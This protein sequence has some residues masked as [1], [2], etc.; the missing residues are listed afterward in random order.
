MRTRRRHRFRPTLEL[1]ENRLTPSGNVT[2]A[3]SGGNLTITGDAQANGIALSQ[4]AAGAI[5]ITPDATTRVNGKAAGTPVTFMNV[6]GNVAI[7]L[8]AGNDSLTFDLSHGNLAVV[9]NLTATFGNGSPTVATTTAGT[10]NELM[11]GG[12]LTEKFGNGAVNTTLDQFQVGGNLTI[13]HGNGSAFVTFGVDPANLGKQFNNVGGNLAVLNVTPSGAPAGGFDIDDLDE[14]NVAGNVD[15]NMGFG[16]GTGFAG[17]TS[18][19]SES[20]KQVSVGGDLTITNLTGSMSHGD[21]FNDG[22]EVVNTAVGGEVTMNLGA[23]PNNTAAFGGGSAAASAGSLAITGSGANDAAVV[24]TATFNGNV[25]VSLTGMGTNSVSL[26][27]V[28]V[29]G[30][31]AVT[32]GA[33]NDAVQID[34][35]AAGSTFDGGVTVNTGAGNDALAINAGAGG[36]VTTFD[37][38]VNVN[39]GPGND[40]LTLATRGMVDF[41]GTAAFDGG[42]GTNTRTVDTANL[43]GTMPTFTNFA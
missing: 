11:V 5:T 26:N 6:T 30:N 20:G 28:M 13:S 2:A 41:L 9:G 15:V 1:L 10:M 17:W 42:T 33:G 23:G 27:K 7:N 43:A 4:P 8:G 22:E 34:N 24:S 36:G 40:T 3:L 29:A 32:T 37:T 14:T 18:F 21:F 25:A 12:N 39:L 38:A 31:T 19:G 35:L 16:A